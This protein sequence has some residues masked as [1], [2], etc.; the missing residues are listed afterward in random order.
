MYLAL[1]DPH[2]N[3]R[4]AEGSVTIPAGETSAS[5]DYTKQIVQTYENFDGSHIGL[6]ASG[7]VIEKFGNGYYPSRTDIPPAAANDT[8]VQTIYPARLEILPTKSPRPHDIVLPGAF[9]YRTRAGADMEAVF[10]A[11]PFHVDVWQ[12][13]AG[14]T[15]GVAAPT[16]VGTCSIKAGERQLVF[17]FVQDDVDR[18]RGWLPGGTRI[19]RPVA[20]RSRDA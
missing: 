12:M 18:R 19:L 2:R 15:E 4:I 8:L 3:V 10:G 6:K 5:V 14:S 16:V 13:A 20:H 9:E 11:D 1:G 17:A 7:R